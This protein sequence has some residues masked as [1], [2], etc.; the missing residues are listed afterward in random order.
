DASHLSAAEVAHLEPAL[1]A[2][3]GA[4]LY[5]RDGAV[6]NVRLMQALRAA[7]IQS[8][9]FRGGTA[10]V[11]SLRTSDGLSVCTQTGSRVSADWVV[12]AA[13]AWT[14]AIEGL[15]RPIPVEPLKGQMLAVATD[16]ARSEE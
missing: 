8:G 15:P 1:V 5:Q 2:P 10:E 6:D 7:T 13:G 3:H 11:V 4:L 12:L 14:P 16:Q 9:A